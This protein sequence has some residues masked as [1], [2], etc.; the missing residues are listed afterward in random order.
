MK[1]S[2]ALASLLGVVMV[3]AISAA[4]VSVYDWPDGE[5][6]VLVDA[7]EG[8]VLLGKDG[9]PMRAFDWRAN[10]D[11]RDPG[12]RLVDM[13][14]DGTPEIVGSG[15]PSFVLRANGEPVF[16]IE[17]GCEQLIV[18]DITASRGLD[19]GCVSRN[20]LRAFTGDGQFAW[21]VQ[22]GRALEWCQVEDVTGNVKVD[23]ECKLRGRDAFIRISDSGELL[24][25]EP[26]EAGMS[27]EAPELN[28]ARAASD[29][30]LKGEER[31]DFDGDGK[32]EERLVVGEGSLK[33]V[34]AA[35]EEAALAEVDVRG[36]VEAAL[37]KQLG[38]DAGVSVVA[39]TAERIYVIDKAEEEVRVR[40]FS[41]D[42]SKYRRV[43]FADLASVYANGFED[44]AAAQE[45]VRAIGERIGQCYASRLR[46]NAYAG[47]GR[48]IV[49]LTVGQDGKVKEVMQMH[50][51]VGD[52]Q[53]ERCARQALER[54]SYPGAQGESGT[55]NVNILFTFR[56]VER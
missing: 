15:R 24:T 14:G 8:V 41:A 22:P 56:D 21:G 46:G 28:E 36:A 44:A 2:A 45:A 31:F 54:G 29:A 42:A 20:E 11:E 25:A 40:D 27:G 48:Q 34:G 10:S 55:I 26:G 9:A 12:L 32:A 13:L 16:E 23:F 50:S 5:A 53:V 38:E 4:E 49:Q 30:V 37:V 1:L 47:S 51:D 33:I 43:P 19:V 6:P 39:V 3:P 7:G 35:G 52:S 18:A 17:E